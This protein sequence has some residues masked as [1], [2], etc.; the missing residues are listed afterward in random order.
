MSKFRYR[1]KAASGQAV[2]GEVEA[3]SEAEAR[4][5]LRSQRLTPLTVVPKTAAFVAT[6]SKGGFRG[7]IK[8]KDLQVF[9]RQFSVLIN[10]GIPI[11][12]ALEILAQGMPDPFFKRVLNA[13]IDDVRQGRRLGV[14]M[15][16]HPGAFDRLYVNMVRAGEEG[17]V[18]DVVLD[19][20]A[21]YIEKAAKIKG[22]VLGALWYPAAII[23]VAI[24]VITAILVFVI[25]KFTEMFAAGGKQLP[26]LTQMVVNLSNLLVSQWYVF[27]SV[28]VGLVVFGLQFSRTENG[29]RVLD[30]IL[31]KIPLIGSLIQKSAI[32]RFS[33]TMSTLL[34]SGV[35]ILEALE[36]AAR[37]VGNSLIEKA[38][39]RARDVV[40]EGKSITVPLSREKFMPEM[41]VQMIGVGEQTGAMD[42]MLSKVADFY[43]DEVDIAVSALTSVIEPV[44][45][46]VLGGIVAVLVV[47]MYLPIFTMSS[48][49]GG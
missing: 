44:L 39:L 45:M 40:A 32:A 18:L 42:T 29:Q 41:V 9:T 20:L 6:K 8:T 33:R 46:V 34:S 12:Q 24:G 49:F 5:I 28:V 16:S 2:H 11:L 13:V 26:A 4:V 7:R 48:N 35:G 1:A 15:G 17:G 21:V 37:T 22:K 38:I 10:S 36:I 43:E 23:V 31:I 27:L 19:R 47:S 25:P 30:Q 3:K 14:A